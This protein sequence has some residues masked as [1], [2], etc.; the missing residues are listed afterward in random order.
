MATQWDAYN[1]KVAK[2]DKDAV[3]PQRDLKLEALADMLR[4]KL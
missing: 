3:P 1:A 2:G 4:G